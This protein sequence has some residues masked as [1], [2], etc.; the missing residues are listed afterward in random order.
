MAE[1]DSISSS[2]HIQLQKLAD[3]VWAA[4]HKP[5]GWA[6]ANAGIIDLGDQ[7]LIFDTLMTPAAAA[8]LRQAAEMLTGRP[9]QS[10]VLS[11]YHNDHIWGAQVF[12][13]KATIFTTHENKMLIQTEGQEE[14]DYFKATAPRR[15]TE[16]TKQQAA[17]Q[18]SDPVVK[19]ML[20]YYSAI[21]E[22]LPTLVVQSPDAT[23]GK[24]L[25]LYGENRRVEI[26]SF[27]GG[28]TA[29]DAF[30]YLPDDGIVFLS[31]CFLWILCRSWPTAIPGRNNAS[32]TKSQPW[33]RISWFLATARW[34]AL[35]Q[36]SK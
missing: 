8:D 27:G 20:P 22:S 24:R 31:D 30:L 12:R 14:Y 15:V 4:L 9:A 25:V 34:G 26:L 36:S 7:T 1:S 19:M 11:H 28:H 23:F 17:T 10:V 33:P 29:N 5:G 16:L 35:K 3:G 2:K 13:P 21:V 32:W 6:I 18:G